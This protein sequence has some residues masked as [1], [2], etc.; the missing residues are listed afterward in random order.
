[1]NGIHGSHWN[2]EEQSLSQTPLV[3]R[4]ALDFCSKGKTATH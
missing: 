2:F 3:A 4:S 1:M